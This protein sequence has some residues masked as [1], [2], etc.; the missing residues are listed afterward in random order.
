MF[1][2]ITK[3]LLAAS[4]AFSCMTCLNINNTNVNASEIQPR[5][6]LSS[7]ERSINKK[8]WVKITDGNTWEYARVSIVGTYTHN[9]SNGSEYITNRNIQVTVKSKSFLVQLEDDDYKGNFDLWISHLEYGCSNGKL[10][11]EF[12]IYAQRGFD[13]EMNYASYSL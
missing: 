2:K 5:A 9:I 1:K 3:I 13:V 8:D 7:F 6:Q 10:D 4:L 11:V 12:T